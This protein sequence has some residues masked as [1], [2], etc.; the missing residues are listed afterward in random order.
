MRELGIADEHALQ[1]YFVQR[2]ER[3]LSSHGRRLIGWDEILEGG[4]APNATV[5]SW[6]GI[7][8]AVAAARAGHEAVL[9][10]WPTLYFDNRQTASPT[11][12]PGRGRVI[13]VEDVY[14]FDATPEALNAEQQRHILGVQAQLWSEHIRTH[15]R[16]WRMAFP[17][18]AALAELGWSP[19]ERLSWDDFAQRLSVQEARYRLLGLPAPPPVAPALQ[20]NR[21]LGRQLDMCSDKLVLALEDD[22]PL[23][24]E[25]AVFLIDVMQ[26][27]WTWRGADLSGVTAISASVGQVPFN[28]QIG[29]AVNGIT[30][31]RP[32]TPQGE[33]EVRLGCEG[34]RIAVLPLAPASANPGVTQLSPVRISPRDGVHDLCFTFTAR[35]VDPMYAVDAVT[36]E[37]SE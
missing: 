10:A 15:D 2:M 28:F 17:R 30:F 37:R 26:P 35:G 11:E 24:G 16:V 31:R 29:D 27:C 21:R 8:G 3:F 22:F 33:L 12:P 18:G 23:E 6:R 32:A 19:A 9:A 34:E 4:L 36:L 13:G 25:R 14:K 5:M 1:S 20:P 7:D